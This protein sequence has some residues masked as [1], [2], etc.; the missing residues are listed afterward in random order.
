MILLFTD[1]DNLMYEIKTENVYDDFSKTK[2]IFDFTNNS[3]LSKYYDD[4][5]ALA[6]CKMTDNM[7]V[8]VIK[9]FV[10]LK[11]KTLWVLVRG[12]S[13]F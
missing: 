12:F 11:P 9:E 13:E 10:V 4:S 3:V 1:T 2:E 7:R 8:I 6:D 5:K